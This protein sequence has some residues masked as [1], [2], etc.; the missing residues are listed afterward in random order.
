[1]LKHQ[2]S[3]ESRDKDESLLS[4]ATCDDWDLVAMDRSDGNGCSDICYQTQ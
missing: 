2:V 3:G 1:M 4:V